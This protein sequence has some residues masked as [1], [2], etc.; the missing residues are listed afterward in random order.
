LG[1]LKKIIINAHWKH[2]QPI[3]QN[4]AKVERYLDDFAEFCH[5]V[6]HARELTAMVLSTGDTAMLWLGKVLDVVGCKNDPSE[7]N[8]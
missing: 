6:K 8:D 7:V 3:F 4:K 5:A 2:F 1:H